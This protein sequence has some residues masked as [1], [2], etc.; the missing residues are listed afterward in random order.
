[1]KPLYL[2]IHYFFIF[3]KLK[4]QKQDFQDFQDFQDLEQDFHSVEQDRQILLGR[5]NKIL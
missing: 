2:I 1:M 3:V 4:K 5:R